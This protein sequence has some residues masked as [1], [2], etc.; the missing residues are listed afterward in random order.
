MCT[1]YNYGER[2]NY[3]QINALSFEPKEEE[4]F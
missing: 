2:G 4:S 1:L 3:I